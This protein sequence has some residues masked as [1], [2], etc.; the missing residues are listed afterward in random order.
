LTTFHHE[1][2]K[3]TK[4]AHEDWLTTE[5]GR[6]RRPAIRSDSTG[7]RSDASGDIE[8][9]F[10]YLRELRVFVVARRRRMIAVDRRT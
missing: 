2:I 9:P 10:V 1:A 8:S 5:E 3:D 4:N 7:S 6:T